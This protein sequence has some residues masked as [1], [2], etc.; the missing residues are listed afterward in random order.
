[1]TVPAHDQTFRHAY[2]VGY[3]AHEPRASDP[4]H[5]DFEAW[6]ARQRAA[7]A[8]RCAW[9]ARVNDDS[10]CDLSHP[11][12]AHHAHLEI[13]L[14]NNVDFAH[15]E[16]LFPGIANPDVVGAWIDSDPNL[17]LYCWKHHRAAG[18]GV[19]CLDAALYEASHFVRAGTIRPSPS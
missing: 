8:W 11:L 5:I 19:H 2:L 6:K 10:A 4:H 15:L 13:A 1:M 12:E 17:R 16:A 9:A 7:G 14:V 18:A 3:A